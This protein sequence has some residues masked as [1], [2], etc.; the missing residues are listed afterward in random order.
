MTRWHKIV[1]LTGSGISAESGIPTFRDKGGIWARY[2]YRE[3]ATPEGFAD[4]PD[5]VHEF[6][7]MRRRQ[8]AEVAPN[9]AHVA[10]ARLERELAGDVTIVTQNI[11]AGPLHRARLPVLQTHR[12]HAP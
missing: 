2:D 10:L 4:N 11:D 9:A 12:R 6:Y 1:V 8:H 5:L 3:V 7:N